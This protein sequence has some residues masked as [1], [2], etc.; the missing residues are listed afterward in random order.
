M[1][2]EEKVAYLEEKLEAQ[3]QMLS[4]TSTYMQ[5]I[6]DEL[7][8]ANK[9]LN[10]SIQS[11]R[12]IQE[13]LI[14]SEDRLERVFPGSFVLYLP[15]DKLSGD[16]FW[17]YRLE[18][19]KMAA[20]IDCTGHGVPGAMLTV[21][22]ISILNQIMANSIGAVSPAYILSELNRLLG[23]HTQNYRSRRQVR[24]G[25]DMALIAYDENKRTLEYAG[26]KRPLY[27]LREGQIKTYKPAR[28]SLGDAKMSLEGDKEIKNH[29][30]EVQSGDWIYMSSDGYHDQF[31]G[32]DNFKMMQKRFRYLLKGVHEAY[33]NGKAQQKAL[34][35]YF[36]DWKG[37]KTQIDD[38][39]VLG[40]PF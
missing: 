3:S 31:G 35:D 4:M 10:D 6:Q 37:D 15:K 11:A 32:P 19:R 30:I 36:Y 38:V 25:L 21:L 9:H 16:V 28:I 18:G 2:L 24:D 20:A 14:P 13:A 39:L 27:L 17:V 1:S 26:A 33:E 5:Q 7:L 34:F 23:E 12:R 8:A 40:I 22:T 29:E